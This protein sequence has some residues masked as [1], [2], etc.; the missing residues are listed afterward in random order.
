MLYSQLFSNF[1][2]IKFSFFF[3]E[4]AVRMKAG[5]SDKINS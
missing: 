4:N 1:F 5:A 2:A 3:K